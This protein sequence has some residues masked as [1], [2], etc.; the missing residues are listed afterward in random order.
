MRL[1][2]KIAYWLAALTL[3]S[4]I[5]VSLD[6]SVV[7]AVLSTSWGNRTRRTSLRC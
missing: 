6:Y 1:L 7:Q 3:L 2:G 5:L 4:A